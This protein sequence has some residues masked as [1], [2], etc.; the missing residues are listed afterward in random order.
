MQEVSE[1]QEIC[2]PKA[3][4]PTRKI[5]EKDTPA[6]IIRQLREQKFDCLTRLDARYRQPFQRW[7]ARRF[8]A[9][10]NDLEDAW[11]DAL[12]VFYEKVVSGRLT[13]LPCGVQTWLFAVGG[14]KL[15]NLNRKMRRVIFPDESDR[16]LSGQGG[17]ELPDDEGD[18]RLDQQRETLRRAIEQ[19]S[20]QCRNLLIAK[21]F[22]G[23]SIPEIQAKFNLGTPNST[24]VQLAKCL[25]RLREIIQ[26]NYPNDGKK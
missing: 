9:T 5:L 19:V 13:D 14:N 12:V 10:P 21:H 24:S 22:D 20:P 8:V 16:I 17:I 3:S 6:D 15:R 4:P 23:F 1:K 7:A 11:Q 18:P 26:K 25:A 2:Q